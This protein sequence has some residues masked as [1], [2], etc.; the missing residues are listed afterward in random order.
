MQEIK[1]YVLRKYC[2]EKPKL[3]SGN[4]AVGE[5]IN[6]TRYKISLSKT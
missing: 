5:R 2:E 6:S 1:I 4:L 3:I